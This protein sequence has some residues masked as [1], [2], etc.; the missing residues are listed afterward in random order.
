MTGTINFGNFECFMKKNFFKFSFE[1]KRK[2]ITVMSILLA[3]AMLYL[4]QVD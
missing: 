3:Q 4:L 1:K 2:V